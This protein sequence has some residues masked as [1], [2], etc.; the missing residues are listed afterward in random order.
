MPNLKH[1]LEEVQDLGVEPDKIRIPGKPRIF[2]IK[3]FSDKVYIPHGS[4]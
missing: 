3:V 4:Y 2:I 1:L